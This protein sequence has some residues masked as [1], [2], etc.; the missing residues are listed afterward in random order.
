MGK[1]HI[2]HAVKVTKGTGWLWSTIINNKCT[3]KSYIKNQYITKTKGQLGY[4]IIN[5][6]INSCYEIR[7]D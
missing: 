2:T 3:E 7:I 4:Q 5:L 6:K 1:L